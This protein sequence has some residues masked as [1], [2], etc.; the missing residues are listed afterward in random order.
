[1]HLYPHRTTGR[2]LPAT[3]GAIFIRPDGGRP[4]VTPKIVATLWYLLMFQDA[5]SRLVREIRN[6]RLPW[7]SPK[8][9]FGIVM[10]T[11]NLTAMPLS[12][13]LLFA[14]KRNASRL[15]SLG[16]IANRLTIEVGLLIVMSLSTSIFKKSVGVA[17]GTGSMLINPLFSMIQNLITN[18][19]D[20]KQSSQ[21]ATDSSSNSP[22]P[23]SDENS[24]TKSSTPET[25]SSSEEPNTT[26]P[27][28][29]AS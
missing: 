18:N 20:S 17:L 15:A 29:S 22:P 5:Q 7:F 12:W 4:N 25:G 16:V 14:G 10:S 27:S 6:K 24:T 21:P 1:M 26:Q 2:L 8:R 23:A 11:V 13:I 3:V 28:S 19:D 9:I